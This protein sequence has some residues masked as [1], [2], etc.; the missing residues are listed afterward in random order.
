MTSTER[1]GAETFA[2]E[3]AAQLAELGTT[4]E[5]VALAPGS[6]DSP[7]ELGVL[8]SRPLGGRTLS[9]LRQASA[10]AGVVVAHGSSTLPACALAL[11]MSRTPFIYRNIGDP[12]FWSRTRFRRLRTQLWLRRSAAVVALTERSARVLTEQLRVPDL[13]VSV[14]P[15]GVS[16]R[17]HRPAT[18]EGRAASRRSLGIPQGARVGAIIGALSSEKDVSL[19]IQAIAQTTDVH[20]L[21]CGDGPERNTLETEAAAIAPQRTLLHR[22]IADPGPA[23]D[24][25]DFLVVSS[26][27]EGLPA[28]AIEAG[29]RQ[30]PVASCDVGYLREIVL[31]GETGALSRARTPQE[32]AV[33][34]ERTLAL[35]PAAGSKARDH[36]AENF[37]MAAVAEKW[38]RLILQVAR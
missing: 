19:A 12:T 27:S 18:A 31:D 11:S 4:V 1:R 29:L 3:L 28:V 26:R 14:I 32:L 38:R 36:C 17:R 21:V 25:A 30:L 22:C 34:I 6:G 10:E 24:A 13:R 8:G 2:V 20:L 33:A 37:E 7:L 5:T 15:T 9:A 35:G 23:Y 16:A